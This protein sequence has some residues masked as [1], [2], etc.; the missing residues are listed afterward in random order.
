[1]WPFCAVL[2]LSLAA[3]MLLLG[4][5]PCLLLLLPLLVEAA[6]S[7]EGKAGQSIASGGVFGPA[8]NAA[9]G[10]RNPSSRWPS[11]ASLLPSALL[12]QQP[13]PLLARR[14]PSRARQGSALA[15]QLC[16]AELGLGVGALL[17]QQLLGPDELAAK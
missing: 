11:W 9:G 5:L 13:A 8:D 7:P 6:T 3:D 2:L 15:L 16:R 17:L 4:T 1:M 10:N 12:P 14:H